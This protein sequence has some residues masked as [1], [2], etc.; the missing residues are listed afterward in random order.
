[1]PSSG[2]CTKIQRDSCFRKKPLFTN[3]TYLVY[4]NININIIPN[5]VTVNVK[6]FKKLNNVHVMP[7]A[8]QCHSNQQDI[9]NGT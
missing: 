1:L 7:V 5:N 9:L 4:F 2:R 3:T 8:V 6:M